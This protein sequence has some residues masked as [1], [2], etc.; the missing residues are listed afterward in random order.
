MKNIK[1]TL[2]TLLLS[3]LFISSAEA[4]INECEKAYKNGDYVTAHK[5]CNSYFLQSNGRALF[6]MGSMFEK[7]QGVNKSSYVAC[8]R[9]LKAGNLEHG[10]AFEKISPCYRDNVIFSQTK[11]KDG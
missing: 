5:E 2:I 1:N 3:I 8:Q 11:E 4:G 6:I 9:F 10:P 7:G